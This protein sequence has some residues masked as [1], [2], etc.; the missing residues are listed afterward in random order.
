MESEAVADLRSG[1]VEVTDGEVKGVLSINAMGEPELAYER[2]GRPLQDL[3]AKMRKPAPLVALRNRK[4]QLVQQSSR[5]R[6]SLEEAMVRGDRFTRGE[7][8]EM[9]EHPLLKQMIS[10]ILFACESGEIRWHRGLDGYKEA[11]RIA[12]PLRSA[13]FGLVATVAAGVR[14]WRICST[15]QASIPRTLPVN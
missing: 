8:E 1:S 13:P 14:R 7:L 6:Q 2:N 10:S 15:I 4:S 5:M 9:E 12:H 3:P 11:V